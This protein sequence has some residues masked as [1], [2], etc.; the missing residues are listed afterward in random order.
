M[1]NDLKYIDVKCL[2]DDGKIV[3]AIDIIIQSC[4]EKIDYV[5]EVKTLTT[6]DF[7]RV[8]KIESL[9]T[10]CIDQLENH[11]KKVVHVKRDKEVWKK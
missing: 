3:E 10:L 11:V 4:K 8:A 9:L 7:S 5:K 1:Q 2:K 6:K